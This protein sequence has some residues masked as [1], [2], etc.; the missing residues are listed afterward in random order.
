MSLGKC[1]VIYYSQSGVTKQVAEV[2]KAK[3]NADMYFVEP[4]KEYTGYIA[5]IIRVGKEKLTRRPAKLKTEVADFASYDAIFIGFPVWY[6]TVPPFFQEY[7][8]QCDLKGKRIIPFATT[9]K[10]GKDASLA[11][12]KEILPEADIDTA[13]Y[14]FASKS[15]KPDVNQW[16]DDLM[17]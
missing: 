2:I 4:E 10:T 6:G 17:K 16:L 8:K 12:L 1:A 11:T 7:L 5:S 3:A 15:S 13:N 9:I 14:Y